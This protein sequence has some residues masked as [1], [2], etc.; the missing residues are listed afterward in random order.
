MQIGVAQ[1]QKTNYKTMQNDTCFTNFANVISDSWT[2]LNYD[3][4]SYH[5]TYSSYC[6]L[7]LLD[8]IFDNQEVGWI[9]H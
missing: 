7:E 8:I 3:V 1:R 4:I 2:I 5:M 6:A 9:H